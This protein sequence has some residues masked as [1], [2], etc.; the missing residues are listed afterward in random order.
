MSH[1]GLQGMKRSR[2]TDVGVSEEFP[3]GEDGNRKFENAGK[4]TSSVRNL[5]FWTRA[6]LLGSRG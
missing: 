2:R 1:V 6:R 5:G 4:P 3:H